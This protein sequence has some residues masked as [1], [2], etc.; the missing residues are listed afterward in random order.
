MPERV[1]KA[2]RARVIARDGYACRYCGAVLVTEITGRTLTLDHIIPLSAG[3]EKTDRNLAVCC[4]GCN[5]R[6]QSR[7]L[8]ETGMQLYPPRFFD[9][10]VL[11]SIDYWADKNNIPPSMAGLVRQRVLDQYAWSSFVS[12]GEPP[13]QRRLTY[14]P[15]EDLPELLPVE[16]HGRR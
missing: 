13:R 11:R 6:K 1:T 10:S 5:M 3:G 14:R 9:E 15:F 2:M 7:L 16:D 4:G 12:L 8:P